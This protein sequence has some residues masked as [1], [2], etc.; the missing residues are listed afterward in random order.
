MK[1]YDLLIFDFDGT[2]VNTIA[3]IAFYANL[4]LAHYGYASQTVQTVQEAVG[5]G[6]HELLKKLQPDFELDKARLEEAVSFF[7]DNY[8]AWPVRSSV[9]Y[10]FVREMLEGPL[11][12]LKKAIVTNKPQDITNAILKELNL[13]A[14]FDI[15]IGIQAG[16]PPKPDPSGVNH[17]L[18]VLSVFPE[19]TLFIG[20]SA[21]DGQTSRN[22]GID[23]GWVDYGYDAQGSE[24]SLLR[25]SG[26]GDWAA[27]GV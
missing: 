3:D 23:F 21:I 9:P 8:Q 19:K 2:L 6:V 11:C 16:F 18:R 10:P 27:L 14:S 24:G 25:F 12:D 20:D 13:L 26:A 17:V 4:T 5:W 7:K 1:K 22:A 15:V